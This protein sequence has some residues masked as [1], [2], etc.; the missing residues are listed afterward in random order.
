MATNRVWKRGNV[1]RPYG[2]PRG[3][4]ARVL[5]TEAHGR[6]R[7]GWIHAVVIGH[8]SPRPGFKRYTNGDTISWW[9][10]VA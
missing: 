6:S 3:P 5:W 8:M 1:G 10:R 7:E 2:D 4:L 9:G